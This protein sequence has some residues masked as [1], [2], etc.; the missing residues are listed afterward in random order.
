MR[1]PM[2]RRCFVTG[3]MLR[4]VSDG[5][6][7]NMYM[8]CSEILLLAICTYLYIWTENFARAYCFLFFPGVLSNIW[9]IYRC[10]GVAYKKKIFEGMRDE[11]ESFS[12]S[13]SEFHKCASVRFHLAK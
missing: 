1:R 13:S 4:A 10:A 12:F 2:P 8:H 9:R 11:I 5:Y 7:Y 6:I 3:H